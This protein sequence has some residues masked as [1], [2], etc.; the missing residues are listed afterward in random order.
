MATTTTTKVPPRFDF[1]VSPWMQV[2]M[3]D[4]NAY[5]NGYRHGYQ[6]QNTPW[7]CALRDR[8]SER[9]AWMQG[10]KDGLADAG[11]TY[12]GSWPVERAY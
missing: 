5:A 2:G 3:G 11:I 12:E 10:Y 6:G 9:R 7:I 1:L 8:S 4:E